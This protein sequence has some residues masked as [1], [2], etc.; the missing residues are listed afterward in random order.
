MTENEL[1]EMDELIEEIEANK[2]ILKAHDKKMKKLQRD[3]PLII[4]F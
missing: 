1:N 3:Y 4:F 2:E